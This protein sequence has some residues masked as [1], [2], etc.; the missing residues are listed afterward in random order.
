MILRVLLVS[1]VL[2]IG[3]QLI[4]LMIFTSFSLFVGL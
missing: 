1:E 2:Q 3:K 4:L